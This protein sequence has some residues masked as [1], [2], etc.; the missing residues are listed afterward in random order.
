M[1][2]SGAV[3]CDSGEQCLLNCCA[4]PKCLVQQRA[5]VGGGNLGSSVGP[6]PL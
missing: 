5:R 3:G 4:P 6:G 2:G 1:I